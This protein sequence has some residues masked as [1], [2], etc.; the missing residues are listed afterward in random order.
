M[1]TSINT[2][3]GNIPVYLVDSADPVQ[4]YASMR[5]LRELGAPNIA[6][7]KALNGIIPLPLYARPAGGGDM[8]MAVYDRATG[9]M[10]E[11]FYCV[12]LPD[13]T[14]TSSYA[15][16]YHAE[17]GFKNLGVDN[18]SMQL[19]RGSSSVV[20]MLSCLMQVGIS[21]ARAGSIN[22][23]LGFTIANA[24]RGVSSWPAKQGDGTDLNQDTPA[25]GQWFR[26][27][28]SV[29]LDM[30]G[31]NPFTLLLARAAQN[32]GGM[33]TDK[34]LFDHA[35][36]CEDPVNEMQRTGTNPWIG[37]IQTQ[38][39]GPRGMDVNDFPWHLTQWAPL[40]WGKP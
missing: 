36:N 38:Y 24:R 14:W 35:F 3:A 31:L 4:K 18:Y 25:E 26:I 19:T 6:W 15:G 39:G 9:M 29:K 12:K 34:N 37:D 28:P 13:G 21:E 30:L 32:Y 1:V 17:P 40:D 16:F 2:V 23:A 33:A 7:E 8:S 10:R 22:H 5:V 27:P 20:S 11:Y